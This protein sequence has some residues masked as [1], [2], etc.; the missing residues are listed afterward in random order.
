MTVIDDVK[1]KT[2]IV[3]IVGGYTTLKKAGKNLT[4]LCPFHTEKAPSFFIY[5]EQQSWHCFGA[6]NTGGDVFSF[7]MKKE[8]LDFG[9]TLRLMAERAGVELP[10]MSER[11]VNKDQKEKLYSVNK[12]A[13]AYFHDQLLNS[14]AAKPARDYL[15][16]RGLTAET[17]ET[18]QLGFSL[19]SW[20]ALNGHLLEIGFAPETLLEAGLVIANDDGKTHDR[21]R[22]KV[23]FP[24][25]DNRGRAL[26]FGARV[27]DDSQPKYIN[28]PQTPL[29]DKSGIIY[30]LDLAAPTIRKNELAV[31]V[32]GYM[33]VIAVH[34]GGFS[35]VVAAMGTSVTE[36]QVL[37]LKRMTPHIALA[38]DADSA[39][40][41]A[42]LR[43]V[44]YEN[45]LDA[46]VKVIILPE[47]KDPDDVIRADTE[48]WQRLVNEAVPV[49][50]YTFDMVTSKLDM[51][52]AAGQTMAVSQLGAIVLQIKDPVRQAHYKQKLARVTDKDMR[53]I[54][55]ALGGLKPKPV[56]NKSKP[57]V[58]VAP[59]NPALSHPIE[60]QCLALLLQHPE[61]KGSE[62]DL[63]P[64]YFENSENR[65]IYLAW[66]QME[67]PAAFKESL[68]PSTW[69]YID[70]L[71]AKQILATEI[72]ERYNRFVLRM[73]EE[74]FKNLARKR[75]SAQGEDTE[76]PG[77][78]EEQDLE[79]STTLLEIYTKRGKHREQRR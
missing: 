28:S 20:E 26:G 12:A 16:R 74:H 57:V 63:P 17:I 22:G 29:F 72:D 50:D 65:E 45:T 13:A 6:C 37:A 41:E 11:G 9:E 5:P 48:N 34:Q 59:A 7:V 39:G 38:L 2:D 75:A 25:A 76:T 68:D 19:N 23:M 32:E 35:N 44:D 43:C 42:M 4:A 73:Q 46:E 71:L 40:E 69:E 54:E 66:R 70:R 21:F 58:S 61:I 15:E 36:R 77:K 24:I 49:L 10:Q 14:P 33:D 64:E 18:F 47:G 30:G 27:L 31:L 1:Q 79:V 60:E 3:E 53:T 62:I 55:M 8:N 78:P 67:D 52:T 51:T 56:R